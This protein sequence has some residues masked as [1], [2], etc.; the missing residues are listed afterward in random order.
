MQRGDL[1]AVLTSALRCPPASRRDAAINHRTDVVE[2]L[3]I[4]SELPF[5]VGW[6]FS[7]KWKRTGIPAL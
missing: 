4:D 1:D 3:G 2:G 6:V 7:E 5:L